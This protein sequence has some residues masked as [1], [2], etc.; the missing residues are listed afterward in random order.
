MS[1]RFTEMGRQFIPNLPIPGIG[2]YAGTKME[3]GMVPG[4]Y[5]S[6][7]RENHTLVTSILQNIGIRLKS[8][9][10]G[11]LADQQYYR[12]K[13]KIDDANKE[14]RKLD[15]DFEEGLFAG[16]EQIYRKKLQKFYDEVKRI[17]A[18]MMEKGI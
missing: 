10:A 4:G 13:E 2:T 11:K 5:Q 9:D 18:L 12:L 8:V 3:R 14:M 16:K 1:D 6:L 17:D 15:K 7:T